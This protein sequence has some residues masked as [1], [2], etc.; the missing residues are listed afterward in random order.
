M[1]QPSE[2]RRGSVRKVAEFYDA[3][4]PDYDLMTGYEK[5]FAR[6]KPLFRSLVERFGIRTAIDAGCGSGFHSLLLAQ[7]GVKVTAVDVSAEMLRR[8]RKHARELGIQ[9]RALQCGFQEMRKS[10]RDRHDALF[11]L[12]NSLAHILRTD[13][14]RATFRS[15]AGV[16]RPGGVVLLQLLNYDRIL[17]RR[18]RIQSVKESGGKTFVRFSMIT[19]TKGSFSISS[20]WRGR[21]GG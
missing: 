2:S 20:F 9:I 1:V 12:G 16:L 10:I 4:A 18:D 17:A 3:L 15:F 11:C 6:E 19:T 5:R 14:L 21:K 7:L 8:L 13:G